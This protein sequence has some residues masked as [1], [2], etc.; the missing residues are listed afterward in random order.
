MDLGLQGWRVLV[1]GATS[2]LGH[3]IARGFADEDAMVMACGRN[4]EHP[5]PEGVRGSILADL[6]EA[7]AAEA[8]MSATV[9]QLGGVDTVIA[10]AG[11]AVSGTVENSSDETW[12][13]GMELNFLSIM[14]LVRS[15]IPHLRHRGGRVVIISALS[16]S[17]PRPDH[18]VSNV[19][20]A[21]VTALA[22][23]LSRELADDG[24]LVNCVAPGRIRSAQLDRAFPDESARAEFS[25]ANIPLRRFGTSEE[26]VPVTLLLGSPRN[27]YITGQTVGVDGGMAWA[28]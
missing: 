18:V 23:T 5:V 16:A 7:G 27:S 15:A 10:A 9:D 13:M 6:T 1:T 20:K 21:G 19:S 11:G 12:Q 2:G 25:D 3:A 17:E 22:K 24:I 28:L 14:R 26:V 4:P 8:L